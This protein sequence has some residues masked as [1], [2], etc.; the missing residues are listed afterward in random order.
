VVGAARRGGPN[1]PPYISSDGYMGSMKLPDERLR[2]VRSELWAELRQSDRESA[3]AAYARLLDT[4]SD[5]A[6]IARGRLVTGTVTLQLLLN[7][8][9]LLRRLF[10]P[11]IVI[12]IALAILRS[13]KFLIGLPVLIALEFLALNRLQ[14]RVNVELAARLHVLDEQPQVEDE[15]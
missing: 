12:I 5:P 11:A 1:D 4:I 9:I 8:L 3:E 10:W 2:T 14:T 13:S 15:I 6:A 7:S